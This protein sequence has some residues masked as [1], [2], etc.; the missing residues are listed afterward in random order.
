MLLKFPIFIYQL[1][2]LI[3]SEGLTL[4][5]KNNSRYSLVIGVSEIAGFLHKLSLLYPK[6]FSVSLYINRYYDYDYSFKNLSNKLIRRLIIILFAPWLFGYLINSTKT[7]FY[8]SSA[9]FFYGLSDYR[10]FEFWYLKLRKKKIIVIFL[11]TDIRS[12]EL[13]QDFGVKNEEDTIAT[14]LQYRENI[15][16][17]EK[18]V[19]LVAH[20]TDKFADHI[21]NARVDQMSY[22][23]SNTNP[24]FYI[25]EEKEFNNN[26]EKFQDLTVI[27]I[28]HAPSDP[29]VKGTQIVRAVIKKLKTEGF[30]I[31]YTEI[32][33]KN[34]DEVIKLLNDSH[35]AINQLYS[36][37][38][39]VFGI[40]CMAN[41]VAMITSAD[42]RIE[43]EL[44]D[45]SDT[46]WVMSKY[47][48][49]YE[50]L[51][52]LLI[53][54]SEIEQQAIRGYNFVLKNYHID[55]IRNQLKNY[56]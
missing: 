32:F 31:Q 21:F 3:I 29:F 34:N 25:L 11:G 15:A 13:L 2:A 26:R 40:E 53:N 10:Y 37:V 38:P 39:S 4:I 47:W 24:I 27:K 14:Y 12:L 28:V 55:I 52:N 19:K 7:F 43:T 18:R 8:T 16:E 54:T 5:I 35:I 30:P 51:K 23:N 44:P 49:L 20:S 45:G 33:N 42:A 17:N 48:N 22:L 41:C 46:A 9:G 36:Y 50:N 6:T 1:L 56:L